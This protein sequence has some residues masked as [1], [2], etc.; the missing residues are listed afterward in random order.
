MSGLISQSTKDEILR[1]LNPVEFIGRYVLLRR[2]GGKYWGCC[3]FHDEKT[4]SFS[5]DPDRGL[6]FCFG[7]QAGG[8][9]IGFV[10][11][12]ENVGFSEAIRLLAEETGVHIETSETALQERSERQRALNLLDRAADYYQR[13][14]LEEPAG[15]LGR[16]YLQERNISRETAVAFRLGCSP[17]HG[18]GFVDTL[19]KAGFTVA[20]AVKCGLLTEN[21]YY[22]VSDFMRGRLIFPICD[23]QGRVLAFAGRSLGDSLPKYKNTAETPWYSKKNTLYGL[24]LAKKAIQKQDVCVLVEGYFDVISLHQVG[25]VTAVASCGTALTPEQAK[26]LSRLSSNAVLMYDSD[27]AGQEAT[28][29]GHEILE[30]AGINVQAAALPPGD[31][32]D[33]LAQ[34]GAEAV[35]EILSTAQSVVEYAMSKLLNEIDITTAEGKSVFYKKILPMLSKV[36][37]SARQEAYLRRLSFYSGVPDARIRQD[38]R[39]LRD[40][41]RG[42]ADNRQSSPQRQG[43]AIKVRRFS[44][45]EELFRLCVNNPALIEAVR[46]LIS[47][48]MLEDKELVPYFEALFKLDK[49]LRDAEPVKLQDLCPEMPDAEQLKRLAELLTRNSLAST[50]DDARKLAMVVRDRR[51]RERLDA[52]RLEVLPAIDAGTMELSDP[53]YKE[54][55]DLKRYFHSKNK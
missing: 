4:P 3:P 25:A 37:D 50:E 33:S 13:V 27:A 8:D 32:P 28:L 48:D 17:E 31:D 54:Y 49:N 30:A 44:D 29:R 38:L 23:A 34:R 24:H 35:Q 6:W 22:G 1:R 21:S 16:E 19:R 5:V 12:R 7:C 46:E 36:S 18:G 10:M 47:P 9:I 2:S 40:P 41:R 15:Q 43:K 51:W 39:W 52:L 20:E 42:S 53:R 26:A 45:E 14:L 55:C 11:R